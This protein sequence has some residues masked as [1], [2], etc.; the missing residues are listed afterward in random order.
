[1]EQDVVWS[2]GFVRVVFIE[3]LVPWVFRI[4]Q[5]G[6]FLSKYFHLLV[7]EDPDAADI[8]TFIE[9][10]QLLVREPERIRV[11]LQLRTE[12]CANGMMICREVL[13][14]GESIT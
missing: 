6:Q 10:V 12:Q 2:A 9:E 1:M 4:S 5:I 13:H 11:S 3:K 14:N 8:S 7:C